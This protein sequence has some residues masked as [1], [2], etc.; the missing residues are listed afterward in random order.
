MEGGDDLLKRFSGCCL[1]EQKAGRLWH[2]ARRK[3]DAAF[4]KER[5][6]KK[7]SLQNRS[8]WAAYQSALV[9]GHLSG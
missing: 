3:E 2:G 8:S 7:N 9:V 4:E 1:P 6:K 5:Y